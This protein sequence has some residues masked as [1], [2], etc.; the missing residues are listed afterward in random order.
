MGAMNNFAKATITILAAL[1]L[2]PAGAAAYPSKGGGLEGGETTISFDGALRRAMKAAGVEVL[3]LKPGQKKGT[4]IRLP[5]KEGTFEPRFGSGY[6]FLGGG[7]RLQV[8]GRSVALRRLVLN[9][10]KKRLA[11]AVAGHAITIAK[12]DE[13]KGR[14][15]DLGIVVKVGSLRLTEKAADIIGGRLHLVGLF[16]PRRELGRAVVA[17]TLF[18]V[19]VT[20]GSITFS[21]DEGFRQKLES[22]GV[23]ISASGTATQLSSVPLAYSLLVTKGEIDP[24]FEHGRLATNDALALVHAGP[25]EMHAVGWNRI[26]L[27]FENGY[28]GEGSDVAVASTGAIGQVEFGTSPSFDPRTGIFTGPA[29]PATLSPYAAGPLN[30]AFGNGKEE[31]RA[32]EP[33][34]TFSFTAG[35]R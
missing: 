14:R 29:T 33:L 27:N 19:P 4:A 5:N 21:L 6:V 32:G 18:T 22:L 1:L 23:T 30:E 7:L 34:G 11:G 3:P 15:T 31:F 9:T 35:V 10:A 25:P 13:V 16:R 12:V 8:D 20:E 26:G 24:Q 17:G 2:L 28:G